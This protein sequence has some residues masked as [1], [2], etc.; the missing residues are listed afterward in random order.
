M[1]STSGRLAIKDIASLAGVTRAAVSNWRSRNEDFPAPVEG[2]PER[3]PL[4]DMHEVVRWLKQKNLLPADAQR[5]QTEL[6]IWGVANLLRSTTSDPI[7]T[8]ILVLQLLVLRKQSEMDA[9][10]GIW[11]QALAAS[12]SNEVVSVFLQADT[13]ADAV[14]I[15]EPVKDLIEGLPGELMKELVSAVDGIPIDDYGEAARLTIDRL[16]GLGGRGD[17][18][19]LSTSISPQSELL[20]HAAAT[21]LAAG[22]TVF[23][24]ACGI[25]GTLLR[26]QGLQEELSL[27]GNDIDPSAI[28]I[29]QLHAYLADV[30][31]TFTV[32]DS[33]TRE[34]HGD[35]QAQLI[36]SEPPMGM[37]FD[38]D[39]QKTILAHAGLDTRGGLFSDELF[40]I[41]AL[42]N[43]A[44]G[45][46]AYI[47]TTTGAG[48]RKPSQQVR[49]ELVARGLVEAVI[50]LPA[51][52]LPYSNIETLLWVLHIPE[53]KP[54]ASVLI[55]DATSEKSPEKHISQWLIDLR[56]GTET[57]IPSRRLSLAELITNDGSINPPALLRKERDEDEVRADL[58]QSLEDLSHTLT[59]M[60]KMDTNPHD[61]I[62]L[63]S[64]AGFTDLKT[65]IDSGV[66]TR[67]RRPFISGKDREVKEGIEA[68]VLPMR[69]G[70]G[71]VKQVVA[72]EADLWVCDGDIL[73]PEIA[74][75]PARIFTTDEHR[76]VV[77]TSM[78]VLRINDSA[79]NPDY[80]VSCINA[81]F[82]REATEGIS[83]AR[84]DFKQIQI[85]N[86]DQ[87]AQEQLVTALG[88]LSVVKQNAECLAQQANTATEAVLNAVRFSNHTA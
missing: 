26:F 41:L 9:S 30:T 77:P 55:A 87:D 64:S 1:T 85:P 40:L 70:H 78:T 37:R 80:L 52:F 69:K 3:R 53:D 23:D 15:Y 7:E 63:P 32:S 86:L 76:W 45:G 44:P 88:E 84:R 62:D 58:K 56:A 48:F 47:L 79:L 73:V 82:N 25:G 11:S 29:A 14:F 46:R 17:V 51:R 33:L 24:P 31:A 50:Q 13:H 83:H 71:E 35:L 2:S 4:F 34:T 22:D 39:L 8:S 43:L 20:I 68:F 72:R 59:A 28:L 74:A 42:G 21:T 61:L 49:Q 60:R 5:K 75:A 18:S 65:L 10:H 38:R 54:E 66:I 6:S 27:I 19:A 81:P 16:L 57:S 36:V 67:L 12:T